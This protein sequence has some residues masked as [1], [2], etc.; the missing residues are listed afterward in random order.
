MHNKIRLSGKASKKKRKKRSKSHDALLL[1]VCLKIKIQGLAWEDETIIWTMHATEITFTLWIYTAGK[2]RW[3]NYDVPSDP[4]CCS[5]LNILHELVRSE[6]DQVFIKSWK[7]HTHHTSRNGSGTKSV[8]FFQPPGKKI[9]IPSNE[10][11]KVV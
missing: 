9:I 11:E 8:G 7:R 2:W 6:A 3:T 4:K 10:R 5:L 1:T